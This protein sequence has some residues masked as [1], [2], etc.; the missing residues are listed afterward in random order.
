MEMQWYYDLKVNRKILLGFILM[1][2]FAGAIGIFEHMSLK[3]ITIL[4]VGEVILAVI[5]SIGISKAITQPLKKLVEMANKLAEG[6]LNIDIKSTSKDEIGEVMSAFNQA[7]TS[8][9]NLADATDKI[10][11]GDLSIDVKIISEEDILA[12]SIKRVVGNLRLLSSE[13]EH[14]FQEHNAGDI[15]IFIPEEKFQGAYREVAKGINDMVKNHISVKKKAMACVAE[16]AKG[17]FNAELEKFPGKKAFINDNLEALRKNLKEVNAEINELIIASKEGKLS[18]RANAQEFTGDWAVLMRGLNGLIDAILEPIKEAADVLEEMSKGNLKV[19]VKGNYKGDHAKIK[20]ALN[21]SIDTL[22]SYVSEI[23]SVLNNLSANN[24]DVWIT[25][26]YR[27]DFGEIKG[28]INKII[29]ALNDIVSKLKSASEQVASG[30]RQVSDSSIALSQGA[31]EQASS[32]EQ[33]TASL[34]E[35]SSQTQLNA[36]SADHV[37]QLV[38]SVKS[39]AVHGNLQMKEMLKS[40]EEINHSSSNISKIIKVIDDIAFQTNILALNAAVE[41]ARAGQ[42]GKG[43]AVVAEEVRNLAARSANAAKET[44]DLI[45]GSIKKV[46]D[47]TNIANQTADALNKIVDGVTEV[48]ALVGNIA[49]ASNEQATGIA[50]INQGI[51]QVS[52]VVQT[53]S[54][55]SEESASASE[56]LASQAEFLKEHVSTFKLRKTNGVSDYFEGTGGMNKTKKDEYLTDLYS[57]ADPVTQ[58]RIALS[59]SEF[60]KYAPKR[61]IH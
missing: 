27:G 37:N 14:M 29:T 39:N 42:H 13:M 26:E 2:V 25:R 61:T 19:S 55:T 1:V 58:Q 6:N 21:D 41:A 49:T 47:G 5:N 44:T 43:F 8:L 31:T 36:E 32:I 48:A 16:F 35:I 15:D 54:A 17:N 11:A 20:E 45:E 28:S 51:M 50:Q 60:G 59:D 57:E 53:V 52:E 46:E 33:L 7:L 10:S 38:D 12:K 56:E 9:Q 34:E 24:L 30:S 3:M 18:E 40:M 23:S 22:S 4:L